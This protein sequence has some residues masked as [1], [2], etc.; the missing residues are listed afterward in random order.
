[1]NTLK[2]WI[3]Q[4]LFFGSYALAF[5]LASADTRQKF[6][7]DIT[8]RVSTPEISFSRVEP[9]WIE[10]FYNRPEMVSDDDLAAVLWQV[11]PLFSREE[12]RPN[13]VEHAVRAW[14]VHAEFRDKEVMSGQEMQDFLLDH[15]TFLLSWGERATS[16]LEDRGR[17]V[18]VNWG[19]ARSASV[20]HDHMLASIT[21]AG[22][23]LDQP[24][25]LPSQRQMTLEDVVREA[26]F[27]FRLDERETEW[28]AM[29]FGLWIP[30][31]KSWQSE[32]GRKLSFD[33][34][35]QRLIR[36]E[37]EKG[38]CHGTHRVYSLMLLWR[39]DQ[40]HDILSDEMSNKIY[41][42]LEYVRELI[43]AS[44]QE[45]GHWPS[46]WH[47]GERAHLNPREDDM[48]SKIISTGHHLEWLA[49]APEELHPP[50]EQIEKAAAWIINV[51][52]SQ[53]REE[54]LQRYTFLSHVGNALSLW[55]GTRPHLFWQQWEQTHP[56]Y[57]FTP[58]SV[59][60]S[61][62]K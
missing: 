22:V 37:L 11:R 30:P 38:V 20:H 52:K 15:G 34:L 61:D 51:A 8:G 62:Q 23:R 31:V 53:S 60:G 57:Q 9:L 50:R 28:T 13:L 25:Y 12:L 56:D 6:E 17:G 48:R 4:G 3:I 59:S 46:N 43:T 41:Q 36:G 14:S 44:Q 24:V 18:G 49:I 26:M 16:L 47:A 45:D 27:D 21:E 29:A 39:I 2:F 55:R 7:Q 35:A 54:V 32:D 40:E 58:I 5:T 42:H 10:P 19:S 33:L 1:M